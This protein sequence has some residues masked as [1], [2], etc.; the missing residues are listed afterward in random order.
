MSWTAKARSAAPQTAGGGDEDQGTKDQQHPQKEGRTFRIRGVPLL[1]TPEYLQTY[2]EDPN[3]SAGPVVKSLA[4]E[5]H[6]RSRTATVSFRK[7]P[8]NTAR[9]IPLPALSNEFAR[10]S[11]LT[12]D[13]GFLG[14][15][16]LYAPP[17]Q[18]HKVEYVA[19]LMFV[20]C[21]DRPVSSP[22][23]ASADTHSAR[24]K[25]GAASTYG[26]ETHC[27]MT[28]LRRATASHSCG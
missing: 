18:Y 23:L 24:S 10:P 25:R 1:W 14:I 8:L 2:L 7:S 6:G 3:D 28:S 21:T 5:V 13:D 15:T 12:L 19:R 20:L 11:G 17:T 9:Q 22:S 4:D 27:P 16:T 26:Y